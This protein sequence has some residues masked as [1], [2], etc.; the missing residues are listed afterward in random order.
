[1]ARLAQRGDRIIV[2]AFADFTPEEAKKFKPQVA[3]LNEKN[4]IIETI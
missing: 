3:I 2:L 1:M 4:E